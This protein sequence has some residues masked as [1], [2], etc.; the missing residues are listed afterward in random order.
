[1]RN[2]SEE[3]RFGL[4]EGDEWRQRTLKQV[5]EGAGGYTHP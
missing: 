5:K 2:K 3:A 1:M 4:E